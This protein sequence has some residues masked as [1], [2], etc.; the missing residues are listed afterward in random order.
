M[1]ARLTT[2]GC[3][4][5]LMPLAVEIP[6]DSLATDAGETRLRVAGGAGT[7]AFIARGCEGQIIGEV[8]A[9]FLDAGASLEHRFGGTP[10]VLGVRGGWLRDDIGGTANMRFFPEVP[11]GTV[12]DNAYANPFFSVE[13]AGVGIGAGWVAH[14]R[15][16]ITAGEG[17][18]EQPEHPL[19]DWSG[20]LRIGST[21]G[22]HF[23]VQ[24]ME[25]VPLSSGGG[26]FT[27]LLGGPF[28]ANPQWGLHGGLGAGG[29]HEGAGLVLRLEHARAASVSFDLTTRLG[30]SG[31]HFAGGVALGLT[32]IQSTDHE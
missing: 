11:L 25:G 26:Y 4:A 18:R 24:W 15:E 6:Y 10:L 27:A 29:P 17:A 7:Y 28:E 16:F 3:V 2:L 32:Y 9:R 21:T 22:R 31:S 30:F 23:T 20:H 1:N 14:R 13:D 8:P 19:N 5:A 12:I